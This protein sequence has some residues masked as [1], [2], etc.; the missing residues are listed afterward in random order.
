MIVAIV[1]YHLHRGGVTRVIEHALRA[2]PESVH[3]VLLCGEPPPEG[4]EAWPCPV[5]VIEGLGYD[6]PAPRRTA[7]EL[8]REMTAAVR[9]M[10]GRPADLWHIHNHSLGKSAALTGAVPLL[11]EEGHPLLLQIH[12]LPEDGRPANYAHLT[13]HLDGPRYPVAPHIHYATINSRDGSF[14]RRAGLADTHLHAL[15]NA[16]WVGELDAPDPEPDP[17]LFLYPTRAIRRKNL[18]ELLLWAAAAGPGQRFAVT[19][20]PENPA[21]RRGY[22]RWRAVSRELHLPVTFDIASQFA[23]SFG[24]L[25]RSAHSV[26][27]TSVAE[28]FGLAFLEPW[29]LGRPLAGRNLP[30]ITDEFQAAGIHLS[31]TYE[32]LEVPVAQVDLPGLRER[33]RLALAETY[34]SYRRPL[35][36]DAVEE[37]LDDMIHNDHIDFGRLDETAQEQILRSEW[38]PARLEV[39]ATDAEVARNAEIIA[40]RY[41]LGQYADRLLQLYTRVAESESGPC[42]ALSANALLDAFLNPTRFNL[43]RT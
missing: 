37:A 40:D 31:G 30:E 3:P 42:E 32:R 10:A 43:L 9:R 33:L 21:A 7:S 15:P 27:T 24:E 8:A 14:L 20:A 11:A 39:K 16:V 35:P 5:A 34:A 19:L 13:A 2:L 6:A 28:G 18:G 1:H 4:A 38:R 17:T 12:D 26:V 22:D 23:G 36:P 41:G 29:L 25:V